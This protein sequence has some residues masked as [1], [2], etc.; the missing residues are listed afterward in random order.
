[1]TSLTDFVLAHLPPPPARVLEVG[2][3][4]GDL[5]VALDDAGHQVTAIDPEAPA[6]PIFRRI[7]LEEI[8]PGERFDAVVASHSLHHIGDL[9][10]AL[11]RVVAVLEA[12]GPLVL[13]EFAWDRF[14]ATTGD[15]YE[16]QRRVLLA[17]GVDHGR[18]SAAGWREHHEENHTY[19]TMRRELDLR[20][21]ER[22]IAWMPHLYRYLGGVAS[23]ELEET[24]IDAGVINAVGFRYVG[25]PRGASSLNAL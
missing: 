4:H 17:A 8:D 10:G 5:A 12:T 14:D 16:R 22:Y 6:G 24:L 3:G 9:G 19:V 11:D 2:C 1:V 13:D 25:M 7:R 15:W 20:F 18:P 23:R 21:E